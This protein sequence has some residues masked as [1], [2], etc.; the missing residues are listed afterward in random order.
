LQDFFTFISN[1]LI[2]IGF[3]QSI[4]SFYLALSPISD[5]SPANFIQLLAFAPVLA[6]F[7]QSA[8]TSLNMMM[9]P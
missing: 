8:I 5:Y 7:I 3:L 9:T 1:Q 6:I 4:G 2:F